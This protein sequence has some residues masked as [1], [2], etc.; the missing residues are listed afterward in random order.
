MTIQQGHIA[1]FKGVL[2]GMRDGRSVIEC[3]FVW[4]VGDD[5]T[6]NWPVEDGYVLEIE[7]DPSVRVRLA[8]M[9]SISMVRR[10]RRCRR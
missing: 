2:S 8:P 4:K 3:R 5:M 10:R 7:G 1:G 9:G 6:P